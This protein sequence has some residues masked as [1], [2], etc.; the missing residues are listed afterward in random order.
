MSWS[1]SVSVHRPDFR[2][3]DNSVA[4]SRTTAYHPHKC[5]L[6]LTTSVAGAGAFANSVPAAVAIASLLLSSQVVGVAHSQ[7]LA[8]A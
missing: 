4:D 1:N 8:N 5:C 3:V 2:S 7:R 6:Y